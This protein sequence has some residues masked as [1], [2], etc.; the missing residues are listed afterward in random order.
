MGAAE[1]TDEKFALYERYQLEWHGKADGEDRE[2]FESFLYDSPVETV[3]FCYRDQVGRLVAVGICDVSPTSVSSVYFY[4]EPAEAKRSLGTFGVLHE[5]EWARSL[6][7]PFYYLG[8][9]VVG[10]G[11]M[12]YKASFRPC[13]ILE[14]DGKWRELR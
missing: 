9:W 8:Y 14:P 13:E 2:S 7:M 6:G 5:I 10:C 4:H 11:A 3:E 12:E 1:P